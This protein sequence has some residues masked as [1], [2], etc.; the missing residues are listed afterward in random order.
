VAVCIFGPASIGPAGAAYCGAGFLMRSTWFF[1]APGGGW[2]GLLLGL[3]LLTTGAWGQ[4]WRPGFHSPGLNGE[5]TVVLTRPNGD[6]IAGGDFTNAGGQPGADHVARWDGRRWLALGAGP[7]HFRFLTA[8]VAA[9][10]GR[11]LAAGVVALDSGR[12]ESRVMRWNGKRWQQ[13]GPALAKQWVTCL[14]VAA[15]GDVLVGLSRSSGCGVLRWQGRA[16]QPL[17]PDAVAAPAT[18]QPGSALTSLL[19][20]PQGDIVALGKFA[21]TL[22]SNEQEAARWTGTGWQALGAPTEGFRQTLSLALAANGDLLASGMLVSFPYKAACFVARWDG[23][24]WQPLPG[25]PTDI[26]GRVLATPTGGAVVTYKA[27]SGSN[28]ISTS[29]ARWD[30]TRWQ[31]RALGKADFTYR[32][33]A[34]AVAANGDLLV[35]DPVYGLL[36]WNNRACYPL[37]DAQAVGFPGMYPHAGYLTAVAAGASGEVALAGSFFDDVPDTLSPHRQRRRVYRWDGRQRQPLGPALVG[38]VKALAVAPNGE[39]LAGG[40]FA[41]P[42]AA[43]SI[44]NVARWDGHAWQPLGQGQ[45]PVR[46]LALAP[47][48][49]VFVAGDRGL[50]RWDGHRWQPLPLPFTGA[51]ASNYLTALVVAPNGDLVAG[52]RFADAPP[53]DPRERT[54]EASV[55]RWNGRTWQALVG[56]ASYFPESLA[57]APDGGYV[58]GTGA[59][60]SVHSFSQAVGEVL[61][62]GQA[63]GQSL[64]GY[65]RAVAVTASGDIIAGGDF[66]GHLV[67][68][69]GTAWQ[70]LGAGLSGPV[71]ALAAAPNGDLIVGGTFSSTDD[72]AQSLGLWG[73]YRP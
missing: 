36:G 11:L 5:P 38:E 33:E 65:V 34:L 61:R 57:L 70:P 13:V 30:G 69:N 18:S 25:C 1:T 28:T 17:V 12:I 43:D 23:Q 24:H 62:N 31:V 14:A 66:N 6:V 68:W 67:R 45:P 37:T 41:L 54:T 29:V 52:G 35:S 19:V 73:I 32:R 10:H 21:T 59:N 39:V 27:F 26:P 42:G 64:S 53:R 51:G 9:P 63:L 50:A 7:G 72:K 55:M 47:N 2:H 46:A 58:L 4:G 44:R 22:P 71:W 49:D 3:L 40:H 48:G 15:N 60:L 16:W 8:L 20:T 56:R